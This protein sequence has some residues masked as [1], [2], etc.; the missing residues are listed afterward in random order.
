VLALAAGVPI[1]STPSNTAKIQAMFADIGLR[2][3]V[4]EPE[5]LAAVASR[6]DAVALFD[7]RREYAA[8]D[9]ARVSAYKAAARE[10]I[11][12]MFDDIAAAL[13]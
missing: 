6:A 8:A 7:G 2:D 4:L 9:W 3:K 10:E 11:G 5:A 12:R 1:L 13:A